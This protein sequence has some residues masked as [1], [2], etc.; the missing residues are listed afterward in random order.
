MALIHFII[1]SNFSVCVSKEVSGVPDP[2]IILFKAWIDGVVQL[3]AQEFSSKAL[4]GDL[5]AQRTLTGSMKLPGQDWNIFSKQLLTKQ[6]E[7]AEMEN[8]LRL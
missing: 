3:R 6:E 5:P 2:G 1:N 4:S 7:E 8:T